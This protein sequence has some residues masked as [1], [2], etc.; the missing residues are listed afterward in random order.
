M[1][2]AIFTIIGTII[3]FVLSE[4]AQSH[5]D[6][7]ERTQRIQ[8]VRTLLSLEIETNLRKLTDFWNEANEIDEQATGDSSRKL[9][10][11]HRIIQ[12]PFP[13]ISRG[14]LQSQMGQ[15]P[16]AMD[17]ECLSRVLQVYDRLTQ[18]QVLRDALA[19]LWQDQK[20]DWDSVSQ[21]RG[22][23]PWSVTRLSR[24][25]DHSAPAICD[26]FTSVVKTLIADGNPLQTA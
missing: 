7:K 4:W 19:T 17:K 2:E 3:G 11:A 9:Q 26:E 15:L 6:K 8:A 20:A 23:V 21:G 5:R 13:D 12:L 1:V 22:A 10:L 14:A 16:V 25:F 18:L 24:R